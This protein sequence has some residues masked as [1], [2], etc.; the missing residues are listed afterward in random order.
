MITTSARRHQV[1]LAVTRPAGDPL[2]LAAGMDRERANLALATRSLG[3]R[4]AEVL[5]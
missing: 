5:A 4:V 3:D 1:L 2:L